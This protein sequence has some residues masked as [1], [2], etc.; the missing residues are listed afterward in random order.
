MLAFYSPLVAFASVSVL[1][2]LAHFLSDIHLT[3]RTLFRRLSI[4]TALKSLGGCSQFYFVAA[5]ALTCT[6]RSHSGA[7]FLVASIGVPWAVSQW[8]PHG[9]LGMMLNHD[10]PSSELASLRTDDGVVMALHNTAISAPQI[11]SALLSS[12]VPV[13]VPESGDV[14][15]WTLRLGVAWMSIA[16]ILSFY[17]CFPRKDRWQQNF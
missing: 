14:I 17:L 1:P 8:V 12:I 6:V 4:D 16:A 3:Q 5:M 13:F 15:G 2:V 11:L 9:L 10:L 7:V